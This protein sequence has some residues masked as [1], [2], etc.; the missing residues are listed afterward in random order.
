MQL[1]IIIGAGFLAIFSNLL[2]SPVPPDFSEPWKLRLAMVPSKLCEIVSSDFLTIDQIF[3]KY[4]LN[5]MKETAEKYTILG[6]LML[7]K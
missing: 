4:P 6:Q 5:Y 7:L 1:L 2:Y 3:I